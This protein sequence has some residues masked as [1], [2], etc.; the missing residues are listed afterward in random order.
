MGALSSLG[1]VASG[2][3]SLLGITEKAVLIIGDAADIKTVEGPSL[4][5]SA[6]NGSTAKNFAATTANVGTFDSKV[7]ANFAKAARGA[8]ALI[9]DEGRTFEFTGS[10]KKWRFEV[11]FNPNELF[12]NGYGGEELPIHNFGGSGRRAEDTTG[13]S[14]G[15]DT[16][17]QPQGD[18]KAR[19]RGSHMASADTRIEMSFTVIFDK[20]DPQD[21]FYSDK[22]TLNAIS[23]AK[24]GIKAIGKATGLKA[25]N[26]VQPEVEALTACVRDKNKRLMYFHWG[27]MVYQ[28]IVNSVNAEYQM[29]NVNGEPIRATVAINMVL[30]DQTDMGQDVEIW[31]EEYGKDFVQL[32]KSFSGAVS[33][34]TS[35]I[36]GG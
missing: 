22:F 13:Q 1:S 9:S 26:S 3:K 19:M 35:N 14:K 16:K 12:I 29:F 8:N 18:P 17:V 27:D 28:G 32:R 25:S 11:Q 20:V 7:A 21:A 36:A 4:P 23:M 6:G 31:S 30:F 2:A 5:P 15:D 34:A 24:G 10:L 33:A